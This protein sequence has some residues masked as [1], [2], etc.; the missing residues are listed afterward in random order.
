MKTFS[1]YSMLLFFFLM[2]C[3]D[4]YKGSDEMLI[5][6]TKIDRVFNNVDNKVLLSHMY[7][8]LDSS[9]YN[10]ILQNTFLDQEYAGIDN[11]LPDFTPA[12][13][14]SKS[15]Y[16]RGK[17]S[18]LEILGPNNKFNEGIGRNGIGFSLNNNNGFSL[19]NKPSLKK[20]ETK[21]LKGVDTVSFTLNNEKT[22]WFKAFYTYGI[23]TNLHT[24]YSYYNPSFITALHGEQ[25][26]RY[27]EAAYLKTAYSPNKLFKDITAI[28]IHCTRA[29]HFRIASELELLGCTSVKKHNDDLLFIID[30]L[31][32]SV[33][34]RENIEKSKITII[35]GT[36]NKPD[37]RTIHC[38]NITIENRGYNT[39]WRFQ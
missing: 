21:F 19:D 36:L 17:N 23:D 28:E 2:G 35:A 10:S 25:E 9:T 18:Y 32:L 34:L 20:S 33:C 30:D 37:N 39:I 14:N 12:D 5:D 1:V 7:V 15:V 11:G 4:P 24:W 31:K 6:K 13:K 29:D 8:V 38:K 22:V 16:V 27:T 3:K 26:E